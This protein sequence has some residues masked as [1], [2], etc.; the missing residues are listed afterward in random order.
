MTIVD[1][2]LHERGDDLVASGLPYEDDWFTVLAT[3]WWQT[4]RHVVALV[5][6]RHAGEIRL[7]VKL[8]RRPGDDSGIENEA[9]SLQRLEELTGGSVPAPQVL[10]LT[11]FR[12][13]TLL[14]ETAVDGRPLGPELV[15]ADTE[16]ATELAT[17]FVR[18]LPR[19]AGPGEDTGA[20]ARLLEE[21]LARVL[22]LVGHSSPVRAL[23]ETTLELLEPLRSVSLP[24]VFEHGDLSHPNLFVRNDGALAA[25][26][27]ER[28]EQRGLPIHDMS[29]VLQYLGEARAG[30]FDP[31]GRCRVFDAAFSAPDGWARPFLAEELDRLEVSRELV[32]P[33]VLAT[34][35]R[36]SMSLLSRLWALPDSDDALGDDA[37]GVERSFAEDRDF[38]L[39][40]HAVLRMDALNIR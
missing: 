21:P 19:T 35:A 34:W 15:R 24:L 16:K 29:F 38:A 20:F 22:E 11:R 31:V 26:D 9:R 28:S 14:A 5:H 32:A 33:L 12:S 36:S 27:W 25:I 39:W 1:A 8:P 13:Q 7:V 10:A 23:A 37:A 6:D 2:F 4:S 40:R 18:G 30:V 3:P 17:E